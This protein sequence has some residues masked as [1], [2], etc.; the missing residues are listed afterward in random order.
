MNPDM[1]QQAFELGRAS[2]RLD[3]D[4]YTGAYPYTLEDFEHAMQSIQQDLQ[5]LMFQSLFP[6]VRNDPQ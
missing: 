4:W 1:L 6:E 5:N 3:D 2:Q